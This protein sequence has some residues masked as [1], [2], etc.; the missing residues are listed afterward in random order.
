MD[1]SPVIMST[2]YLSLSEDI[3]ERQSCGE[4]S[5]SSRGT[6][7]VEWR[8]SGDGSD[9]PSEQDSCGNW[10]LSRSDSL[11]EMMCSP[12]PG[13]VPVEPTVTSNGL[14]AQGA[15]EA[16]PANKSSKEKLSE[17]RKRNGICSIL[18]SVWKAMKHFGCCCHISAVDVVE[19]F[20]PPPNLDPE[21]NPD[22]SVVKPVI[23][24]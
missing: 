11:Q 20:V 3:V 13:Q 15:M 17:C 12:L 4:L 16:S 22:H 1:S 8:C 21:P 7:I 18:M 6:Y 19:P 23:I 5:L 14:T 9:G 24:S 2:S 10:S